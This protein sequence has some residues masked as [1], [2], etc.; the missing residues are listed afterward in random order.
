LTHGQGEFP[1][2]ADQRERKRRFANDVANL[3]PVQASVNREKGSQGPDDWLPPNR[4]YQCQYLSQF[5]GVVRRYGLRL[6][7]VEAQSL[8]LLA[9]RC[10]IR[11]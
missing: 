7:S 4:G 10:R 8:S 2:R 6:E 5:M 11:L 3:I 9:G 1:L